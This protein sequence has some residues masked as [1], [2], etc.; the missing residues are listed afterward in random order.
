M[1]YPRDVNNVANILQSIEDR[2]AEQRLKKIADFE[3]AM[4]DALQQDVQEQR[5]KE[6]LEKYSREISAPEGDGF[7]LP[8]LQRRIHETYDR[9]IP[10]LERYYSV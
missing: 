10:I 7:T 4:E 6:Q 3:T 2:Y 9:L 5:G 8:G 1:K